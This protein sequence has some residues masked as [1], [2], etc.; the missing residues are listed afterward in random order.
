MRSI[1]KFATAHCGKVIL[2]SFGFL[3]WLVLKTIWVP[4]DTPSTVSWSS[5]KTTGRELTKSGIK[6]GRLSLGLVLV[7]SSVC[8][9]SAKSSDIP[10]RI[11]SPS[12][13]SKALRFYCTTASVCNVAREGS[14]V[15][16]VE[17]WF[18]FCVFTFTGCRAT[19]LD[20]VT[21]VM[22]D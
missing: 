5:S 10:S 1:R 13:S 14:V 21:C 6:R 11:G 4:P 17:I 7:S 8:V 15:P 16:C 9:G 3:S 19:T 20:W 2:V 12:E 18:E 22:P